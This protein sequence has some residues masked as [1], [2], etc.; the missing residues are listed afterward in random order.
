MTTNLLAALLTDERSTFVRGMT[1]APVG[2]P[3]GVNHTMS[4]RAPSH[5][6]GIS[7]FQKL[8]LT[9]DPNQLLIL[10]ILSRERGRWPSS[11]TLGRGAMD[12][13]A[14]LTNGA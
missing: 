5:L 3:A 12:A 6:H 9:L 1:G 4:C 8:S 14:L 11:L 13:D 2:L 7:D 10:A